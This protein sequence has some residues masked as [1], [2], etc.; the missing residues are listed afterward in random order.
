MLRDI[1]Q[2]PSVDEYKDVPMRTPSIGDD[3]SRG[4][5][6]V[7]YREEKNERG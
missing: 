5:E 6:V 7:I 3:L 2:G 4:K 1:G